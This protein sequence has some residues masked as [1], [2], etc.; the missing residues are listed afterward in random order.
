VGRGIAVSSGGD[1]IDGRPI[2]TY[3]PNEDYV[4]E[5]R[6]EIML[7]AVGLFVEKGFHKTTMREIAQ[8]CGITH[9]TLY[10]YLGS[11]DDILH[12]ALASASS[13]AA[14]LK[15]R[16]ARTPAKD[17]AE[18]LRKVIVEDI[19]TADADQNLVIFVN[20]EAGSLPSEVRSGVLQAG[21]EAIRFY[22]DFIERGIKAGEFE[23]RDP[24]FVAYSI[25]SYREAWALRRWFLRKQYTL[26]SYT[27]AVV[28]QVFSMLGATSRE[29]RRSPAPVAE[30]VRQ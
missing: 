14:T 28:A 3:S 26:D 11:K 1:V 12:L 10:H 8:A 17:V 5:R 16:L 18:A 20:R 2:R 4:R 6:R 21:P 24:Y 30:P 13:A 19:R 15:S 25:W 22:E 27:D 29:G 9:G 7:A 23:S